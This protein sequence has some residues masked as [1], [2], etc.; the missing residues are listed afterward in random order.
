MSRKE[1]KVRP[2]VPKEFDE[3]L[4]SYHPLLRKLLYHRGLEDMSSAE[5]FLNPDYDLDLH[6][7][8]LLKGMEKAVTRILSAIEN[9]QKVLIYSDYDADGI[10]GGVMLADFFERIGFSN[11]ENYIPHRHNEGYGLHLEAVETFKEKGIELII[12]IDC[13]ISDSGE[14]A[15]AQDLGIDVIITDH[16]EPGEILPKAFAIVNPKQI[17]C[18]YP[19]KILCGSGVAFK[20]VQAI[21]QKNRFGLGEGKEKWLLDLVGMATLSDMVPL[22]G[23]NRALAHYGLRV[24]RKSPRP[25]LQQIWKKLRIDQR[26]ISEDDIGFSLSPRINAASRMGHPD[27]AFRLLKTND[28]EEAGIASEHLNKINDERKGV[29]ASLVKE[30][31]KHIRERELAGP[32]PSVL[33]LGNPK[34]RPSLLGLAANSV[35]DDFPRPIFLWGRNGDSLLKG[36][37]RSEGVTDMI[38][39]ME[40]AKDSFVQF[41][42]HKMAGGFEVSH[43]QIHTLEESLN[44]V[45]E[46][47]PK[48]DG[49]ES[50]FIDGEISMDEIDW[51]MYRHIERLAPFGVGNPKPIFLVSG[52]KVLEAKQFGKDK[53]H[54]EVSFERRGKPMKAISFFTNAE[55][56]RVVPES[57]KFVNVVATL[58]KSMFRSF[59]ELRLRIVDIV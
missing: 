38:S 46:T 5:K 24:L 49:D 25:G 56:Y 33:V 31:K 1:Y 50:V 13:G 6:D 9:N 37:C 48:T 55:K 47:L 28:I 52:A 29:V 11:F 45:F 36:S 26:Y 18:T 2:N 12:T 53:N 34:W 14:V 39:L 57:G 27:D 30:I 23:E 15:R 54:L 44:K 10:P 16:H 51:D 59:P 22:V 8:F 7:P 21:L 43:E 4:L 42:G 3:A 40:K 32:L 17:D 41:G 58:E 20:L 19:E 35:L